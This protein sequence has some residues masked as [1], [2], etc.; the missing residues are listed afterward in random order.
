[1]KQSQNTRGYTRYLAF[2]IHREYLLVGGQDEDQ[3]WVLAPRRVRLEKFPEWAQK[4][5]CEGDIAVLE[6]TTNVW[7]TYDVVAPLVSRAL[8]ANAAA[9]GVCWFTVKWNFGSHVIVHNWRPKP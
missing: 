8:V 6:T 1:M 9:V 7:E 4:N 2:D 3:K 5:L